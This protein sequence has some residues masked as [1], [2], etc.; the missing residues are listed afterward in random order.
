LRGSTNDRCRTNEY[1][2]VNAIFSSD[3]PHQH[4]GRREMEKV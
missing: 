1:N 3:L 2:L 4:C